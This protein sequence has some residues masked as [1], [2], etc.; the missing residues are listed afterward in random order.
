MDNQEAKLQIIN[1]QKSYEKDGKVLQV[2]NPTKFLVKERELF[3]IL[4]PSGCGK[5]T[6]LR[7]IAGLENPT[8]GK[9]ILNG[10]E[11]K[12]PAKDRGM[13]FQ[14]FT[15]FPWLKV[16]DNIAFGLRLRRNN[17]KDVE[18]IVKYYIKLVELEGFEE[19][20]PKDL[21]GGMKQRVALA[22]T[23]VNQPSVLLMD[24]PFGA[25]D[26][27]TRWQ[28]Q[29]ML[30]NIRKETM[31]TIVFVTH[32]VEEAVFLGDKVAVFSARPSRLL[33]EFKIQFGLK[34]DHSLKSS[35]EF[36]RIEEEI[37]KLIRG[38]KIE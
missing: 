15:S 27:Q 35:P 6:L 20:Y 37:L 26:A 31:V 30:L 13:V 34:R 21:S 16:K 38:K 25:L 17:P 5:T 14:A 7:M 33:K 11:V 24:E 29:E 18:Q 23:L 32:D 22:R 8:K 1:L 36:M 3:V 28:M 19:F 12:Y 2:L 10:E 9:V 4:G